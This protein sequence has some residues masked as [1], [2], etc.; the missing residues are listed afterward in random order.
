MNNDLFY[1]TASAYNVK[2]KY[3]RLTIDELCNDIQSID[4][5]LIDRHYSVDLFEY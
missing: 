4:L 1:Q 2:A 5:F 3:A